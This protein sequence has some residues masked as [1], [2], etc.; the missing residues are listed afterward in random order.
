MSKQNK[1]GLLL[2]LTLLPTFVF[3]DAGSPM[4]WFGML[5]SLILNAIIGWTESIILNKFKISNRTWLI[6]VANYVSMLVGLNYIAPHF[7]TISGNHDFWGGQTNYGDYQLRGFFAGMIYSY[8]VTLIIE[9][10]FFYLAL[11]DKS[12]W[13]KLPLPFF[14]ANTVTCSI[15]TLVYYWIVKGGEHW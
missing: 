4:M 15:M 3:A 1:Y 8:F 6:I 10:P 5:H 11:K 12:Q 13:K 2:L 14:I 7:A 9:F